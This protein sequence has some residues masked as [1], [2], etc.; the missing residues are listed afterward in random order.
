MKTKARAMLPDNWRPCDKGNF[1]KIVGALSDIYEVNHS[2]KTYNWPIRCVRLYK[3][4][5]PLNQQ[6]ETN[7]LPQGCVLLTLPRLED[8]ENLQTN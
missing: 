2:T 7:N 4:N 3:P 1:T 6:H 5:Y 8:V